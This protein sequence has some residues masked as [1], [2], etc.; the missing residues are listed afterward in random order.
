MEHQMEPGT[1]VYLDDNESTL[2]PADVTGPIL[3]D[4]LNGWSKH[5][6]IKLILKDERM[7]EKLEEDYDELIRERAGLPP[8]EQD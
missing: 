5:E 6:V 7:R 1:L 2:I 4:M 3:Y 8:L